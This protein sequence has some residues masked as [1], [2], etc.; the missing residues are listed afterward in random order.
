VTAAAAAPPGAILAAL[1]RARDS[2]EIDAEG[3]CAECVAT[4]GPEG[5]CPDHQA[6]ADD[7]ALIGRLRNALGG[8]DAPTVDALLDGAA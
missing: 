4:R 6:V 5:Y 8:L 2:L 3:D 7:A 1:D